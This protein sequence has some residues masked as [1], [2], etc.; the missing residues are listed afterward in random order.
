[1]TT[2][3][4]LTFSGFALGCIY[5]LVALGFTIIYKASRVINFAQGEL[6][7]VGAYLIS[8]FSLDW[9]LPFLVAVAGAV[10]ITA[11]IGVLF[12]RVILRRMIGR[13]TFSIVMITIGLDI[14]L[15]SLVTVRWGYDVRSMGDP[16]GSSGLTAGGVRFDAVALATIACTALTVALLY[17]FFHYTRYGVA[18]RA[19]ALDQEAALAVGIRVRTV[20]ALAWAAAGALATVG[21]L[22]LGAFPRTLDPTTGFIALRA[23]PAIILGGLDSTMGAV[24]GGVVIGLIEVLTAGYQPQYAPWLGKN[25]HVVAAYL[26][27][28]AVLLVRPYG[29]FGTREV[30]RV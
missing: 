14:V 11:G 13:P 12:E 18:M 23:F 8:S 30:E 7:L 24:V 21:G 10:A 26:V 4:Q 15:R 3:L 16:W 27:M 5:A 17:L 2:F 29:L 6:L 22:F 20:Y 19:T 1:V 28:L 9:K 25:F